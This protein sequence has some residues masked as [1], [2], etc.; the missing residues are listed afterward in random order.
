[1]DIHHYIY[2]YSAWSLGVARFDTPSYRREKRIGWPSQYRV[3]VTSIA[4][5][6]AALSLIV[7]AIGSAASILLWRGICTALGAAGFPVGVQIC[8]GDVI[9]RGRRFGGGGASGLCG[10]GSLHRVGGFGVGSGHYDV[11]SLTARVGDA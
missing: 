7:G 10:D 8:A 11:T 5:D 3:C 4:A 6:L 9:L 2:A 1:M